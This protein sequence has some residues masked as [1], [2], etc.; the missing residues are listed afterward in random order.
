MKKLT[1]KVWNET[2]LYDRC[3]RRLE[4][5]FFTGNQADAILDTIED[6]LETLRKKEPQ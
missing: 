2:G 1:N 6:I 3:I 5:N 4:G